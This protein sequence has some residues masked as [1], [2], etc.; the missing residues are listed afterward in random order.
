MADTVTTTVQADNARNYIATFTNLSDGTGE[1]GVTKITA[2]NLNP[3]PGVH[4]KIKRIKYDVKGGAVRIMWKATSDTDAAIV[5]GYGTL[6][7]A[8]FGGLKNPANSGANGDVKFTTVGFSAN[9]A[10]NITI[11]LIKAV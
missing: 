2:A 3:A 11:E 7:Y 1:S 4:G 6:D 9:S 10:Y 5:S 8:D